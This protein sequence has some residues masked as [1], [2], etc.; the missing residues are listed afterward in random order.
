MISG[1][2]ETVVCKDRS[3]IGKGIDLVIGTFCIEH[4]HHLLH[5]NR[6]FGPM[7]EHLGLKI[8]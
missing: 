5:D 7:V 3:T 6:G 8:A 2:S 4:G 1:P